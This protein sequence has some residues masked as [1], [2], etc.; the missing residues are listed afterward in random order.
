MELEEKNVPT[1][2]ELYLREIG[3]YPILTLE[4]E[5]Q[6][7][8]RIANGDKLAREKLIN[9]NLRL[10]VH[11]AK[12]HSSKKLELL[13]LIQEGN[14][15]LIKAVERYDYKKGRFSTY[16]I[17]WINQ[18]II[19][20]L[21]NKGELIRVPEQKQKLIQKYIEIQNNFY[22]RKKRHATDEEI[23]EIMNISKYEL[24]GIKTFKRNIISLSTPIEEAG[25]PLEELIP[26]DE[27]N[28]EKLFFEKNKKE[29]LKFLISNSNLNDIEKKVIQ[30]RY[31]FKNQESKSFNDVAKEIGRTG[32]GARFIEKRALKKLKNAAEKFDFF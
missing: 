16:A 31:D 14:L 5:Q 1:S 29:N 8:K 28:P 15:G 7:A 17:W 24:E 23:L 6:L 18:S 19:R 10:V 27:K 26:D 3:Q 32:E 21:A 11:I 30:M 2:V 13:D 22:I 20:A 4:E 12:F 9:S 25:L